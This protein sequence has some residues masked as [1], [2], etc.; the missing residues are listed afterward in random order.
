MNNLPNISVVMPVYNASAFLHESLNSVLQQTYTDFELLI[1]DDGSTD[2]SIEIVK[3]ISDSR[4]RLI[5]NTH[6]FISSLNTGINAAIGKYL[7]RMDAD[8]VM[9]TKR[10]ETQFHYMES[11]PDID[12]CGSYAEMFGLTN[13]IKQRPVDHLYIICTMLLSNPIIHPTVMMKRSMLRQSGCLYQ[14]GYPCAE[15][16]KLWTDLALKGFRFVNIPEPLIRYRIS[17]QQATGTSP[18][19]MY[20]SSVKIRLEYV[21]AIMEQM[22][23]KDERYGDLFHS[24][25]ELLNNKVINP[26]VFLH[27]VYPV[28]LNYLLTE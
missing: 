22:V 28:Y 9:M 14:S 1:I 2:N 3:T 11:H 4:I 15:D 17:S 25:I 12:I 8:D 24:L 10:L 16:Y 27:A 7:V 21:E 13:G 23:E 6:D 20:A 18:E 5:Q 26:D 19:D